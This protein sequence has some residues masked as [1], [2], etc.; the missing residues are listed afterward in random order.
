MN[1][2]TYSIGHRNKLSISSHIFMFIYYIFQRSIKMFFL[3]AI[4]SKSV[5][6]IAVGWRRTI[7]RHLWLCTIP[8]L[9]MILAPAPWPIPIT[10]L[11]L[12]VSKM[13]TRSSP[14]SCNSNQAENSNDKIQQFFDSI[15]YWYEVYCELKTSYLHRWIFLIISG[16]VFSQVH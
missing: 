9:I 10:Y 7:P 1:F 6:F 5:A 12:K 14:N 2:C 8:N 3:T 4:L 16:S 13:F 11:T 15:L